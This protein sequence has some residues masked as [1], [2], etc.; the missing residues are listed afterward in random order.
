M[1]RFHHCTYSMI[2]YNDSIAGK[3]KINFKNLLVQE[4]N[5]QVNNIYLSDDTI[6]AGIYDLSF[7]D[8]SGFAINGLS[9]NTVIG[10]DKMEFSN[11][12]LVTDKTNLR[13]YLKFSYDSLADFKK[14]VENVRIDS[15]FDKCK[16]AFSDIAYFAPGLAGLN[17]NIILSGR[18]KGRVSSLKGRDFDIRYGRNT[19]FDG[20]ISLHGLPDIN[21]TFID[22]VVNNFYTSRNDLVSI[23][24]TPFSANQFLEIPEN[25][26][27]LGNINFKG[28]FTGFPTDFVA[29]GRLKS[30]LGVLNSDIN[31]KLD[32]NNKPK[33]SGKLIADNFDFGT[34]FGIGEKLGKSSFEASVLGSGV[35]LEDLDAKFD[36]K[37]LSLEL[38]NY[39]YE[40][41]YVD[42][43]LAKGLFNGA[44]N[45][46]EKNLAVDFDGTVDFTGKIPLYDFKAKINKAKLTELKL[47]D[48]EKESN[49][50]ANA[51][52]K[53]SGDKLENIQGLIQLQDVVYFEGSDTIDLEYIT[54]V[55]VGDS[56]NKSINLTSDLVDANIDGVFNL[57]TLTKSL[58]HLAANYFPLQIEDSVFVETQQ[59][60]NFNFDLKKTD[61]VFK[62]FKPGLSVSEDTQL[63]GTLNTETNALNFHLM[64]AKI[65]NKRFRFDNIDLQGSTKNGQLDIY[66]EIGDMYGRD[67]LLFSAGKIYV[68][69]ARD[70]ATVNIKLGESNP[71][72]SFVDLYGILNY[73]PSGGTI[74]TLLPSNIVKFNEKWDINK[75][76]QIVFNDGKALF[77]NVIFSSSNHSLQ[78]NGVLSENEK[79]IL[80]VNLKNFDLQ[81][82]NNAVKMYRVQIGGIANGSVHLS[83]LTSNPL[84][85]TDLIVKNLQVFKDT[86]GDA[87]ILSRYLNDEKI[88]KVDAD[89]SRGGSKNI[90]I[91]GKLL[92]RKPYDLIDATI[93]IERLHLSTL[94][95]Y[96]K[97][98]ASDVKGIISGKIN[99]TGK[100][101]RPEINGVARIQ[102]AGFL[103]DYL[104]TSYNF[105]SDL[106]LID[107][108]ILLKDLVLNDEAG[109]TALVNGKVFHNNLGG[110]SFD[111]KIAADN[112]KC[113][114]TRQSQ[115][116]LYYG[117][118]YGSGLVDITGTPKLLK[119]DIAMKSER[120]TAINLP[121]SNPE[122]VASSNFITFINTN[123]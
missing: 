95:H 6:F 44:L 26:S 63:E 47:I 32:K 100:M 77:N 98:V 106:A 86:I 117:K 111:V 81:I 116:D 46:D 40:N 85:T 23:P 54:I 9:T 110:L 74:L 30:D 70:S 4:I 71:T 16:I 17:K 20:N 7:H 104:N 69:S 11:L 66:S 114:N 72:E 120:G 42:G 15:E 107:D 10:P 94:G 24:K 109:S 67:S 13:G 118:A 39:I 65:V 79:D 101:L 62:I 28:K 68:S 84:V 1:F 123:Q 119:M 121:L 35:K 55:A 108:H 2:N 82:L 80:D 33:Y 18:I 48:R 97:T 102:K 64:S 112:F 27:A 113:L 59:Q 21:E 78:L 50:V 73:I 5:G 14:F 36:G 37:I 43:N 61:D 103:V 76:N 49:L 96:I 53:F 3:S 105:T 91:D 45:I 93:D 83:S 52:I 22:L 51:D 58:K 12:S 8:H 38:N 57:K 90:S 29:L 122:E 25:V 89:I 56:S 34:Y 41:I 99:L 19:R 60:I 75:S 92:I 31:F 115:N 87:T 88:I